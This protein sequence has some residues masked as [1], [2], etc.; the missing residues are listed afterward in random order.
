MESRTIGYY[1]SQRVKDVRR[2]RIACVSVDPG[3]VASSVGE[4][5]SLVGILE[6]LLYRSGAVKKDQ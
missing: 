5:S 4:S 1:N 6:G 3:R 2:Q